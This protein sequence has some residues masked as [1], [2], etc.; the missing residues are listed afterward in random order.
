MI[1]VDSIC[2]KF[3]RTDEEIEHDSYSVLLEIAG[4]GK[5]GIADHSYKHH[6]TLFLID[7]SCVL[8]DVIGYEITDEGRRLLNRGWIIKDYKLLKEKEEREK[9]VKYWTLIA[10]V[11]TAIATL[12]TAIV[13]ICK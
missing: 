5:S 4:L 10:G 9:L 7:K 11:I 3:N 8:G 12:I 13:T 1:T 2:N 6:L